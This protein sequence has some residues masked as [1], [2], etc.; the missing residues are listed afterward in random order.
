MYF[1]YIVRQGSR[2]RTIKAQFRRLLDTISDS[3]YTIL[4]AMLSI[5]LAVVKEPDYSAVLT[6]IAENSKFFP[7]FKDCVSALDSSYIKVYITGESKVQR[8]R[9]GVLSQNVLIVLD[10]N[11]LFTYV[12]AGQEGSVAN[13]TVLGFARD[14]EGFGSTLPAGKY[15]LADAGYISS[16]ITLI[17]FSRGVRYYLKEQLQLRIAVQL[18]GN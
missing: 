13:I 1:L 10:F 15:Y 17:L 6:R 5:Y 11:I 9:K 16:D 12:L 2:Y 8:N 14:I 18:I 7:F 3:F 4:A